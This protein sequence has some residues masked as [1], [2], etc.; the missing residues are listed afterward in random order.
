MPARLLLLWDVDHT[1]IETAGVGAIVFAEAFERATGRPMSAGMA[2]A[3]GHTEPVLFAETLAMH[4]LPDDEGLFRRFAQAQAA[5]YT[6][7]IV[8]LREQGRILPGVS[9]LLRDLDADP[10]IVQ[11]VLTGNTRAAAAIKLGT[12]G[13]D[14]Y[15]DLRIGAYGDDDAHR[16]LLVDI[17][18][19]RAEH[20]YQTQFRRDDTVVIGDT[21]RDVHAAH[22][23]GVR[24]V[25]VASGIG[26]AGDLAAAGAS[27]VLESLEGVEGVNLVDGLLSPRS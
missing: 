25:A 10:R 13:L 12:F 4:G 23:A 20:K 26:S 22:A 27:I 17:A 14:Q 11:T 7:R 24:A 5:S 9:R 1:L 2:K 21:P 19:R 3:Q 6:S 15:L 16:P 18:R 8:E